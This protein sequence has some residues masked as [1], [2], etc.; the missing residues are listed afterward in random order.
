VIGGLPRL[1]LRIALGSS[2]E[3]LIGVTDVLVVITLITVGGDRDSLWSPLQPPPCTL[4]DCLG[5]CPPPPGHRWGH[6]GA[7][8]HEN[9]HDRFV[10]RG[11]PGGD[12]EEFFYGLSLVTAELMY[13]GLVVCARPEC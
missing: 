7:A 6:L 1:V 3:L 11:I 2:N 10:A 13:Q 5:W 4:V 8:L 9:S 12:V